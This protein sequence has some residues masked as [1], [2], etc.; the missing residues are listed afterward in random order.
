MYAKMFKYEQFEK[1]LRIFSEVNNCFILKNCF[2]QLITK[3]FYGKE[4]MF[5]QI[6]CFVRTCYTYY[7]AGYN[8]R[9]VQGYRD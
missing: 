5:R 8:T 9:N 6:W 4:V 1:F 7:T 2:K 3:T